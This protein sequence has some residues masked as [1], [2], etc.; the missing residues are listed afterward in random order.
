MT[1]TP[2]HIE[3]ATL[4]EQKC[5]EASAGYFTDSVAQ[6]ILNKKYVEASKVA[7][8]LFNIAHESFSRNE[9]V[10]KLEDL[11]KTLRGEK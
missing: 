3:K 6:I 10:N 4:I 9:I 5:S 7:D 11:I 8:E 2:S 1:L